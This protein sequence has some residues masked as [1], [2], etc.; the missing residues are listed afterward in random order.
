MH[1]IFLVSVITLWQESSLWWKWWWRRWIAFMVWLTDERR[2]AFILASSSRLSEKPR[3]GFETAQDLSS[4]F[5]EW[6]C[7]VVITSKHHGTAKIFRVL[8]CFKSNCV[9]SSKIKKKLSNLGN[10]PPTH[11]HPMWHL[12]QTFYW[13]LYFN[14]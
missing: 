14:W 1:S 5:V 11:K 2:L 7:A 13:I 10:W 6:G 9:A 8:V 4:G 3:A 12:S